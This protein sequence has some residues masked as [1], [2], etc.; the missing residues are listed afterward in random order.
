MTDY[1]PLLRA[2]AQIEVDLK[3]NPPLPP[4]AEMTSADA[5]AAL[6]SAQ[7]TVAAVATWL[8]LHPGVYWALRH[9]LTALVVMR[10]GWAAEALAALKAIPGA[11]VTATTWLPRITGFLGAIKPVPTWEPGPEQYRG[12]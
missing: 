5:L 3:A 12:R 7:A 4:P 8:T 2:L 9:A 1:G 10:V 11:L 6:T